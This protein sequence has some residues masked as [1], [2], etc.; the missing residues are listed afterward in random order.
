MVLAVFDEVGALTDALVLAAGFV[1]TADT[2]PTGVFAADVFKAPFEDAGFDTADFEPAAF[3]FADLEP[4]WGD[5]ED[6][7]DLPD[8]ALITPCAEVTFKYTIFSLL[9]QALL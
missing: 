5:A 7:P 6:L 1:F 4:V 2:F 9:N 8:I 3:V